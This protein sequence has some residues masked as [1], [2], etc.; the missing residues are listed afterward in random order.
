DGQVDVLGL[1]VELDPFAAEVLTDRPHDRLHAVQVDGGEHR[2]RY[3]VTKTKW[4]CNA[5]TQRRPGRRSLSCHI[6]QA[7]WLVCDSGI[8]TASTT[9]PP[10]AGHSPRRSA[11][12]GSCSTTG[13]GRRKTPTRPVARTSPTANCHVGSP[14][15]RALLS[16][17]GWA[18]CRRWCCSSR[19]RTATPP[20]AT[21]SAG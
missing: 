15:R 4:A 13:C 10:N 16:G 8:G 14:W 20:P 5:N 1:A 9:T 11:A 2:S 7:Y 18:R 3:F 17:R 12:P 19:S 21:H 6:D